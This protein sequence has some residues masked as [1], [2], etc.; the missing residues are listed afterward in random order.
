MT[1]WNDSENAMLHYYDGDYPWVHIHW[2]HDHAA[3]AAV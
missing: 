1:E 3:I 2:R